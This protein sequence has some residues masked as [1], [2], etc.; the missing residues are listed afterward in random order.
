MFLKQPILVK[1]LDDAGKFEGYGSI[2]DATD[3]Y[4]ERV[5]PGA[6]KRSL[7]AHRKAGSMP[8]MFWQ[9]DQSE[10]I[11]F[12]EDVREDDRGLIVKG[13]ILLAAGATERRAY[14]HLKAGSIGGLSIGYRVPAGGA[15]PAKDD[16]HVTV[17]KH[18]DLVEVSVVSNQ[19]CP[20]A[21]VTSVKELLDD[22]RLPTVREFEGLLRDAGFSKA[23]ATAIAA[24]ATPHLR[25]EPEGET[26]PLAAFWAA[27]RSAPNID[28]T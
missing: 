6:F 15:E 2:F 25:G 1:S 24:T 16:P 8:K 17:L 5:A 3:S 9:H 23:K 22:G 14:E 11:G 28:L 4:Q 18:I 13:Q 20:G 7:A 21:L 26:D 19:A 10:P 27:M 12:Y